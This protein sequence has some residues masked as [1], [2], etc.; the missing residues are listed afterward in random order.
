[1]AACGAALAIFAAEPALAGSGGGGNSLD[2]SLLVTCGKWVLKLRDFGKLKLGDYNFYVPER[3]QTTPGVDTVSMTFLFGPT[4]FV[5]L[6]EIPNQLGVDQAFVINGT[7]DQ[8]GN[9]VKF[10][11]D[12][13]GI[14]S[15][16]AI[17]AELGE[18]YLF[19]DPKRELVVDIPFAQITNP[20]D[21]RFKGRVKDGG[22]RLKV[23]FKGKMLYD[24]QFE[25]NSEHAD[26]FNAE[27]RFKLRADSDKCPSTPSS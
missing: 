26:V 25:I 5:V 17:Y 16:E 6:F 21:M 11:P 13:A 27:G 19:G 1:M 24:I 7:Y 12:S 18:N 3:Y 20:D 4:T 9:K 2:G 10:Q 22:D 15:L 23:K 14:A 8:R